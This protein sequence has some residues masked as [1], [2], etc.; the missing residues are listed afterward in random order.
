MEIESKGASA[1]IFAEWFQRQGHKV[2]QTASSQWVDAGPRIFQAFPYHK[3][4]QPSETE[5][6]SLFFEHGVIGLRYSTTW[7]APQGLASYH[8]IF[9]G[10]DY[11]LYSLPKKARHD[12]IRGMEKSQYRAHFVCSSWRGRLGFTVGYFTTARAVW[13]RNTGMVAEYVPCCRRVGRL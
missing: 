11:P 9:T 1:D 3:I 10:I 7:D 12:V 6:R 2:I 8:V 5:L 13:C 4:I